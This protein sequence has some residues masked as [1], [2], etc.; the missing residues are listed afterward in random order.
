MLLNAAQ[1]RA[2]FAQALTD[3]FAVLAVNADSPAAVYDCL[4]AARQCAAPIII[5]TSLW[6]LQGR[7]FGAGDA[8]LGL[9]RY[10]TDLAAL[11]ESER[12]RTVPVIFHTDH[13]KGPQTLAILKAA[14][15]GVTLRSGK[16]SLVLRA[17]TISLDSSELSE[18]QNIETIGELCRHAESLGAD[19]TLE[20]EAGVDDGLTSDEIT[21]RLLGGV[22][23]KYPGKIGLWAPGLGT[24]HGLS[25]KGYPA[26]S[27]QAVARQRDLAREITG[28]G[29][30][31]ALHGSSGLA[32]ESL[33]AA[34]GEGVVK[35]NWSSES[36]LIRS[37]AALEFYDSH[38]PQ[39][40]KKHPDWKKTVMDNG[41]QAFVAERYVPRVVERIKILGGESKAG[42]LSLH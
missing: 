8:I 11:A 19:V 4:E 38:R 37:Q 17:S 28:R 24:Q 22:E 5:E 39:T 35:V 36:L 34:V 14:L 12:F 29:I 30:G 26:F 16:G 18:D 20:M 3:R 40:E 10:L 25:D 1:A 27:A 13:I 7:S 9:L 6:Q 42:K 2:L 31:L 21:R 15:E 33:R 41:L 32:P 23:K